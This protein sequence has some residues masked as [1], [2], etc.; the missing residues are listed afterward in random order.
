M[1]LIFTSRERSLPENH[2]QHT[3]LYGG[4]WF[5]FCEMFEDF[6]DFSNDCFSCDFLPAFPWHTPLRVWGRNFKHSPNRTTRWHVYSK[7][8]FCLS[9][10]FHWPFP[11]MRDE[12]REIPHGTVNPIQTVAL[13]NLSL[14][15]PHCKHIQ[16]GRQVAAGQVTNRCGACSRPCG[17]RAT[18]RPRSHSRS[19]PGSQSTQQ[20]SEVRFEYSNMA[21]APKAI[22]KLTW[23]VL[24]PSLKLTDRGPRY[25]DPQK[26]VLLLP[27][28][29]RLGKPRRETN[30]EIFK[31]S[32]RNDPTETDRRLSC[33]KIMGWVFL[34][35]T[36]W[37]RVPVLGSFLL[38]FS[39]WAIVRDRSPDGEW[40]SC[41]VDRGDQQVEGWSC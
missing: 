39:F 29:S 26:N 13:Q 3:H 6:R 14:H 20:K 25:V 37:E 28:H 30:R 4:K 21:P 27:P 8:F 38:G 36:L 18:M 7:V 19:T 15:A 5:T 24:L 22:T 41:R 35:E 11:A 33:G 16:D 32:Q 34:A 12:I 10:V 2:H 23:I 17:Q 31:T 1:K 40:Q 9:S